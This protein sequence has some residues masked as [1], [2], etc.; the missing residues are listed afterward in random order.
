MSKAAL[1]SDLYGG[2]FL[3]SRRGR[4]MVVDLRVADIYGDDDNE[5]V[6]PFEEILNNETEQDETNQDSKDGSTHNSAHGSPNPSNKPSP[7]QPS[8]SITSDVHS[9]LPPKPISPHSAN[10]SYS[11]QIAQQFS[12][13]Q[14][15]PSQER[16]QRATIPLPQNPRPLA[17][18]STG[19]S[20]IATHE[21]PTN[22]GSDSIF[23]KKPSEMH[24]AG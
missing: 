14:Q 18:T 2:M 9:S 6:V 4:I 19:T 7:D 15:T 10:L 8:K 23:G 16:Q 21:G 13:Y 24:D 3:S 1:D 20:A 5:F 11:A 22:L 12:A 17:V